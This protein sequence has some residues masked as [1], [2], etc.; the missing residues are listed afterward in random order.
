V[1]S[2]RRGQHSD[3][4]R[5]ILQ[6]FRTDPHFRAAVI[7]NLQAGRYGPDYTLEELSPDEQAFL[8]RGGWRRFT[9]EQLLATMTEPEFEWT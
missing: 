6:R 2:E 8:R 3:K 9:D 1:A 5:E 4:G 7:A